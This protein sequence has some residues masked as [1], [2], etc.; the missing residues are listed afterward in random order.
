MTDWDAN[1]LAISVADDMPVD[2]LMMH[3]IFG[4]CGCL[5]NILREP[6]KG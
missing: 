6:L 3:E 1:D 4:N 2:F 5:V